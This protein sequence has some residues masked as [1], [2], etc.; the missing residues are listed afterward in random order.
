MVEYDTNGGCWLWPKPNGDGYGKLIVGGK[1]RKAHRVA[2]EFFCGPIP[3]G[4][5]VLHRCDV[6]LCVNP[7]HLFLG[8]HQDNMDD[9]KAKGREASFVGSNH[10]EAKLDEEA[11]RFIRSEVASGR[12]RRDLAAL[13]GVSYS[14]ICLVM[15]RR[16]WSHV[17]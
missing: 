7:D 4:L 5:H 1:I 15:Q 14:C 17:A 16:S 3:E 11:V 12:S 9:R 8:T 2:W 6:P 13:F 10:P